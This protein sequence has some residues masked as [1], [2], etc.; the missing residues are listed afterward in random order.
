[1]SKTTSR[2][3]VTKLSHRRCRAARAAT[4]AVRHGD[5]LIRPLARPPFSRD[6]QRPLCYRLL[7]HSRKDLHEPDDQRS[8]P[9]RDSGDT[10]IRAR[11]ARPDHA[12]LRPGGRHHGAALD[13]EAGREGAPTEGRGDRP[14]QGQGPV[15]RVHLGRPLRGDRPADGQARSPGRAA[16]R[17]RSR[18]TTTRR[19]SAPTPPS[20]DRPP[21][22]GVAVPH[23]PCRRPSRRAPGM[24]ARRLHNSFHPFVTP[25]GAAS[26]A[27]AG[28]L[29]HEPSRRHPARRRR[30][31]STSTPPARSARSSRPACCSRTSTR[32]P[33]PPSP[34]TCSRASAS[35]RPASATASPSRTAASRA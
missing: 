21:A 27:A 12:A 13:R 6:R 23:A 29:L 16:T 34:T 17:T 8:S 2:D 31:W 5:R 25:A 11:Q 32:S 10:R 20:A 22:R 26:P 24:S 30:R 4:C 7:P 35:A 9:R 19:P 14:R 15:R 28:A 1:M 3:A 18:T 33:A